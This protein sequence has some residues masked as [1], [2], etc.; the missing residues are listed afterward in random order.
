MEKTRFAIALFKVNGRKT[1]PFDVA[2]SP[3]EEALNH[4][5]NNNKMF[6]ETVDDMDEFFEKLKTTALDLYNQ[7]KKDKNYGF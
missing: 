7:Y 6:F 2:A 4:F 1:H 5:V 3:A